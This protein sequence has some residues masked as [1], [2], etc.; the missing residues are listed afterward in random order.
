MLKLFGGMI[1]GA[2]MTIVLLGGPPVAD[3]IIHNAH[4]AFKSQ[5]AGSDSVV[6]LYILAVFILIIVSIVRSQKKH[7]QETALVIKK[8]RR[9]Y[10]RHR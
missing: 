2:L 5:H 7:S 1:I 9:Y 8:L 4:V 3:R 10:P 6:S